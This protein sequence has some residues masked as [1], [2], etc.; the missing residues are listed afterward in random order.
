MSPWCADSEYG[1]LQEVILAPPIPFP[2]HLDAGY[3]AGRTDYP[4]ALAQHQRLVASLKSRGVYCHILEPDPD[5]PYQCYTRDSGVMTP[6]G[7]LITRMAFPLRREEPSRI[8]AFARACGI[9]IWTRV[10]DGTIEG[11]DVLL[12]A[13]GVVAI[14]CN[15]GRTTIDAAHEVASKFR[16]MGWSSR[17]MSYPA[18]F[19]HLDQ[20]LGVVDAT[21]CVVCDEVLKDEDLTWLRRQ[22][23]TFHS[24]P[25]NSWSDLPCNVVSLGNGRIVTVD[26][27]RALNQKLAEIG[28]DVIPLNLEEYVRDFGGPHCLTLPIRRELSMGVESRERN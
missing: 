4:K 6:W 26:R 13:P 24:V 16:G 25:Q 19:I 14:G 11:G 15:G 20:I 1:A 21:N 28:F 18:N 9:P 17:V 27:N 12:L 2:A 23:F 5:L 3:I 7:L 10:E 22:G 8:E